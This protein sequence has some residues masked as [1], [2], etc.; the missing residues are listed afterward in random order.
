MINVHF[1]DVAECCIA[2]K[3]QLLTIFS[4]LIHDVCLFVDWYV[5]ESHIIILPNKYIQF[6]NPSYPLSVLVHKS[7]HPA[8]E[9]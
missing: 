7:R 9:S 8:A 2:L 6:G 3:N 5:S 4:P 1:V